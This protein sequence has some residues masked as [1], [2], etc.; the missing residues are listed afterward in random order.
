MSHHHHE[1]GAAAGNPATAA[2]VSAR[3]QQILSYYPADNAGTRAALGRL[4]GQGRLA[5]SGRLVILPVDQGVEHG[6]H[7]S[8]AANPPAYDPEYHSR[9]ALEAGMS[10][11]AAPLGFIE[12][13]ADYA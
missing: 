7:R 5:G 1:G 2:G 13:V 12:A 8:F 10:G 3:V 6:P 4:L 11:Y 9:F